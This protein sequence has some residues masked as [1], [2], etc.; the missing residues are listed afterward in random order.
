MKKCIVFAAL[1][2]LITSHPAFADIIG[3]AVTGGT[4]LTAGGVFVKLSTPL[5][6]LF[7]PPNSVGNDNFQSPNLYAFD[8]LQNFTLT[9][10]LTVDVGSSPIPAGTV[11]SSQYV[12]FDPGPTQHVIGTVDFDADVLAILTS[13][14]TL[15]GSDFLGR[16]GV[17]YLDPA[18]RGLEPGDSVTIG[19]SRQTLVDV[20]ASSPG[21]YVRVLT[22]A[23]PTSAMPEP[24]SLTLL[25]SGI[26]A[27][28]GITRRKY[29]RSDR[30]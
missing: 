1:L 10:P 12:F 22:A 5:P 2:A 14:T 26:F 11:V 13:T 30:K 7:G 17:N 6:N 20:V 8:E 25:G 18:E 27:L 28:A 9:S 3:G 21:D 23:S 16:P 4:A 24:G 15:A 19:S 29:R